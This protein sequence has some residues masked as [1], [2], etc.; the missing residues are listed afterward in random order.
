M[1]SL[2]SSAPNA[3]FT[4]VSIGWGLFKFRRGVASSTL[5]VSE[6]ALEESIEEPI[7]DF[8][9]YAEKPIEDE[10]VWDFSEYEGAI[11]VATVTDDNPFENWD[12]ELC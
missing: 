7:W 9:E 10:V 8:S 5:A 1:Q 3:S 6:E 4:E 11:E 2:A 12:F